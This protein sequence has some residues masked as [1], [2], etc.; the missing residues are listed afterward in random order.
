MAYLKRVTSR[1][2]CITE[3]SP[4][5][6]YKFKI[7]TEYLCCRNN[8]IYELCSKRISVRGKLGFDW[9]GVFTNAMAESATKCWTDLVESA[10]SVQSQL[11]SDLNLYFSLPHTLIRQQIARKI[12]L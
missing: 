5:N 6:R 7:L 1:Q 2:K 10:I 4:L 9:E 3:I 12:A 8:R 11:S